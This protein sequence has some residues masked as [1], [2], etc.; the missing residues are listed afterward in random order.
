[1][2]STPPTVVSPTPAATIDARIAS[3]ALWLFVAQVTTLAAGLLVVVTVTR[4][5][6]PGDLGRWRFAQAVSSILVVLADVGLTGLAIREIARG[7]R[8]L[9]AYGRPVMAI[10]GILSAALLLALVVVLLVAS[11]DPGAA[12]VTVLVAIGLIPAAFSATYLFQAREAMG[13]VSGLR[14]ISQVVAAVV[15]IAGTILAGTLLAPVL[16]FLVASFAVSALTIVWAAR[17]GYLAPV[18]MSGGLIAGLIVPA[19]PFL[20]AAVAVQVIF[21]AD[22]F[23]I[24]ALRGE[25]ELGLYAAPYS[26]AGYTLILG[27]A[28]ISAAYPRISAHSHSSLSVGTLVK[29]LSAVMG[30]LAVPLSVGTILVADQLV[31]ALFGEAYRKSGPTLAI[32]M[33]LPLVGFLNMTVG[34][35]LAARGLAGRV[36]MV[37]LVMAATNVVLNLLL[38]PNF[39]GIGA[40]VVVGLT[41]L[42]TVVIYL[43]IL[44]R[45]DRT[46]PV[47][48]YLGCLPA[49]AVMAV[50]VI[51]IRQ[52]LDAPLPVT[53]VMGVVSFLAGTLVFSSRGLR[54]LFELA[55][56]RRDAGTS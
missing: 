42:G 10:R 33:T 24:R 55:P 45:T 29:D 22:A 2:I 53:I 7:R 35:S 6:G 49:T 21:N 28:V 20:L 34:Q 44:W 23:I 38:V 18:A 27:G 36:A 54:I 52:I 5:L 25:D 9:A 11:T 46:F 16:A 26:I 32:L 31:V 30:V 17:A 13:R 1:M 40:A 3:N 12:M 15:A 56:R 51:A 50:C 4:V 8:D 39:G 47:P 48:D 19:A 43:W 41:E 37:A 14:S